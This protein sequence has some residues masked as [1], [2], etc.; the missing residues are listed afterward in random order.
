MAKSFKQ[1]Y[2]QAPWRLQVQRFGVIA[3]AL[4]GIAIIAFLYLNISAQSATAGIEVQ[5]LEATRQAINN[6]NASL[7]TEWADLTS[8]AEMEKRAY[9]SG[10]ELIDPNNATYVIVQGYTGREL[11]DVET[12]PYTK[13]SAPTVIK[14]SYTQSL[15][16]WF[17]DSMIMGKNVLGVQP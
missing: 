16:E 10:Y 2:K 15:W 9:A 12:A 5:K 11:P 17:Y 8:A 7:L 6:E 13:L 14:P 1:A 4:V 3:L